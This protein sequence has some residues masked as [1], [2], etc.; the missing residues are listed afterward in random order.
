[1]PGLRTRLPRCSEPPLR[2]TGA[3]TGLLL[4]SVVGSLVTPRLALAALPFLAIGKA[5]ASAGR[6]GGV[7]VELVHLRTSATVC[8]SATPVA[9]SR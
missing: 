7:R 5:A 3:I 8:A 6:V 4:S 1:M 2:L 9:F